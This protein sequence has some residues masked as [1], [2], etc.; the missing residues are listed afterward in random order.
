MFVDNLNRDVSWLINQAHFATDNLPYVG[1]ILPQGNKVFITIDC[2]K[3]H[4]FRTR[5]SLVTNMYDAVDQVWD[6]IIEQVEMV[7]G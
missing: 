3:Y 7:I 5:P 2:S 4:S 1:E 6:S